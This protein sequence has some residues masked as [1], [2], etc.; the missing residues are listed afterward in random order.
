MY[1]DVVPSIL[2]LWEPIEDLRVNNASTTLIFIA[3][4]SVG[5]Q[6]KV[7]D[8]VFQATSKST[9]SFSDL[10]FSDFLFRIVGCVDQRQYCNPVNG[11]CTHLNSSG[12]DWISPFVYNGISKQFA[13]VVRLEEYTRD[14]NIW[15]SMRSL[16]SAGK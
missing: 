5:Y 13:T 7:W 12:G 14:L 9:S 15:S 4:H 8:P 11:S 6:K 3:P 2:N 1:S 10:W 16:G